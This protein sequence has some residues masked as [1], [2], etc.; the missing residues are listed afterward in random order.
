MRRFSEFLDDIMNVPKDAV[1]DLPR[2]S[3]CGDKE[4]YV[5]NHKGL[6]E[7]TDTDIRFKMR[8]GLVH[9]TGSGLRIIVMK[10][11]SMVIN[12]TF[13]RV[14]YEKYGRN[15]RNVEKNL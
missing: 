4:I 7:Y 5:E 14:E 2:V 12:G 8:D 6:S 9:I 10:Y 13:I 11:D 3:I 1:M 15:S